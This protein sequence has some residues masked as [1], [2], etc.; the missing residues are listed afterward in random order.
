MAK[1]YVHSMPISMQKKF[2]Y[3]LWDCHEVYSTN[4]PDIKIFHIKCVVRKNYNVAKITVY[5][6]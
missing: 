1:I 3:K 5:I 6:E 4:F 2:Y